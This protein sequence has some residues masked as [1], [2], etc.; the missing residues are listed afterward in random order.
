MI[1]DKNKISSGISQLDHLLGGGIYIGD[2]VVWEIET[3]IG[4]RDLFGS[5][6]RR[7]LPWL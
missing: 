4:K 7:D 1:S 5:K 6:G 2:N 3:E